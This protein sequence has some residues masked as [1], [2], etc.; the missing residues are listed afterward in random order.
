[1]LGIRHRAGRD[2]TDAD[3]AAS[4]R[5]AIVSET[6]ATTLWPGGD[7]ALAARLDDALIGERLTQW[8][9]GARAARSSGSR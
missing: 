8:I 5:V 7:A 9:G 1:M 6:L 4:H 2:F 3:R